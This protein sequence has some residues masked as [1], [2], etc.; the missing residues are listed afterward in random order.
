MAYMDKHPMRADGTQAF[1]AIMG[2]LELLLFDIDCSVITRMDFASGIFFAIVKASVLQKLNVSPETLINLMLMT[3]TS[4]LPAFPVLKD[5]EIIKQQPYT[6]VDA[7]NMY[8]TAQ[9]SMIGLC[10]TWSEILQKQEPRWEDKYR[11]A[12]MAVKHNLHMVDRSAN[13]GGARVMVTEFERL[14]QDH[15]EYIGLQLPEE[16]YHYMVH[17]GIGSRM[18]NWLSWL[19]MLVFPPLAGGD[20]EEYRRLVTQQLVPI[21]AQ[22]IAL[23]T[24]RMHRAFQHKEFVMRFWFDN[25]TKVVV[26]ATAVDSAPDRIAA[27]W[28]VAESDFVKQADAIQSS[29]G[30]FTF[31]LTSLKD[32][33]FIGHTKKSTAEVGSLKSH[34]EI[35]ANTLWRLLHLRGYVDDSHQ[36]TKWGKALTTTMK[37]LTALGVEC[38][39]AVEDAAFLAFELLRLQQLNV[40][41]PHSEWIG[42]PQRGSADDQSYCLLIARCACLIKLRHEQMGYTGPLS[43]NLLAWHSIVSAVREAGR[44]LVE[45]ITAS[46]F[47]NAQADRRKARDFGSPQVRKRV[48][49]DWIKLGFR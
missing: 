13:D 47:M 32:N 31:A 38:T 16:L 27:T 4:F 45:A 28:R 17:G 46:M 9:K 15:H 41:H 7:V 18:I 14:T 40:R 34:E 37:K 19:E 2:S 23:F 33:E 24:A 42:A 43:K 11:K 21:Q 8:H 22:S 30:S 6:I 49:G 35:L 1:E 3:G 12:K 20:A 29:A 36:L 48:N 10:E 25:T 39:L 5:R 26:K 44:D